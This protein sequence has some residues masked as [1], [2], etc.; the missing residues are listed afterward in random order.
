MGF[1]SD[2]KERILIA[3]FYLVESNSLNPYKE[4]DTQHGSL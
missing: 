1:K 4:N 2:F 3:G